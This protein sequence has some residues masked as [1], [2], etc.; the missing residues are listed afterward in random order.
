MQVDACL[1]IV[2]AEVERCVWKPEG[3]RSLIN[4]QGVHTLFIY[5]FIYLYIFFKIASRSHQYITQISC[6]NN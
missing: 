3:T 6:I 1:M 4:A 5:L 2:S